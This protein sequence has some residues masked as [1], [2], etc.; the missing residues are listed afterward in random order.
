[1]LRTKE[2]VVTPN[3]KGSNNLQV[4]KLSERFQGFEVLKNQGSDVSMNPFFKFS[5]FQGFEVLS[6]QVFK[7]SRFRGFK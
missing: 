3:K 5:S 4:E 2:L 7:V 6:N 1:V